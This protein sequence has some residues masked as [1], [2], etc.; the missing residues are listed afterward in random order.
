MTPVVKSVSV[1]AQSEPLKSRLP[2]TRITDVRKLA[3]VRRLG[4]ELSSAG[5]DRKPKKIVANDVYEQSWRR[6]INGGLT[7]SPER[8]QASST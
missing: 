6:S 7:A 1:S 2:L 8:S 5:S 3:T 4:L